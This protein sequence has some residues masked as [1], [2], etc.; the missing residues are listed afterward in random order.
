MKD[1]LLLLTF[2][3]SLAVITPARASATQAQAIPPDSSLQQQADAAYQK[4]MQL[5]N[6]KRFQEALEQFREVEAKAPQS[7]QGSTGQGIALALL[8]RPQEAIQALERALKIDSSFW[9]ARR[10]LGIVYWTQNRRDEAA[11]ELEPLSKL[12]PDDAP[13]NVILGEYTFGRQDYFGALAYLSRVPAQVSADARLSLMEAEAL[14]KTGQTPAAADR[15]K[16]LVGRPGLTPDQTFEFAWLLG[17]AKLYK[18]AIAEFQKV[19][20]DFPD[21]FRHTYGLALA[22]FSDGQYQQ[23]VE[24]LQALAARGNARPELFAL[25]GVAEEKN[26]HTKEA[27]DAFRQGILS[28]P[29]DP[30]N[31]LNIA[32][33][34][35]EHLN[36]DLAVQILTSGIERIPESHALVLSR[37]IA[38]TLKTQF[39]MARQE[40]N[41]ALQM[42]PDDPACYM[43]LGLLQLE[44][45]DLDGASHSFAESARLGPEEPRAYYFLAEALM[46]KGVA[47][48]TAA[49]DQ[50]R[51]AVDK[52]LALDAS[53]AYAYLDR[54]KLELKANQMDEAIRDL[55]RAR[56][57]DSKSSSV[58][59]LLAQAYQRKGDKAKAQEYFARVKETT[60]EEDREFR[61]NAL[62]QALVVLSKPSQ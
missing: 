6:A 34:A 35:C 46:Q 11:R 48:G 40:Y 50:A 12:H 57:V 56:K 47:P 58:V 54:A 23:C 36:Y 15:L 17:Q 60:A 33:L 25:W 49:F 3:L 59:Y 28:N 29:R 41:R 51:E 21:P 26:G 43:A 4:G 7:P 30:L 20:A 24:G 39:V 42:E 2:L 62:T 44:T 31:Y 13:V 22:F 52:A 32:T 38:Y 45:G 5:L 8:G 55:E 18:E 10:E 1:A 61:R 14:L 53:F 27:Y 19:P 16:S 37:G 9:V